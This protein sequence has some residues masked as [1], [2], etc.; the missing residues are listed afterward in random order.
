MPAFFSDVGGDLGLAQRG[1]AVEVHDVI[2]LAENVGE[3]ALR[4]TAVERHLAAFKSADQARA[5]A[6]PLAFVA[7]GGGLAH[8]RTHAASD[9]LLVRVC[10]ARCFDCRKIHK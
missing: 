2:F 6:R 7:A 10:L 5:G 3:S 9:A 1:Q 8:A 4:N